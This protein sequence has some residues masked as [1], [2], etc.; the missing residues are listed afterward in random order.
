V[1]VFDLAGKKVFEK[2]LNPGNPGR[3]EM[4]GLQASL[5]WVVYR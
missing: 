5:H 1:Q 2:D 4:P 3:I